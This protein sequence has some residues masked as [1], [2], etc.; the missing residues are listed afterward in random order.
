MFIHLEACNIDIHTKIEWL[1]IHSDYIDID[2]NDY[3]N[4]CIDVQAIQY[5]CVIDYY[6]DNYLIIKD[7]EFV[8][9]YEN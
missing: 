1:Y 2:I 6:K 7:G 4:I 3:F 5:L 8:D 9:I